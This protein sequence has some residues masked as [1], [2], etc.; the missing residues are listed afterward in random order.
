MSSRAPHTDPA[1]IEQAC[2]LA[3]K[4]LLATQAERTKKEI[5]EHQK[6]DQM[7]KDKEGKEFTFHLADE[8][9]R[10]PSAKKRAEIFRRLTRKYGVPGYLSDF[11]QVLLK[12][13]NLAS[14]FF[15]KIVMSAIT[16]QIR[17]DS[18]HVIL[19]RET[20][21][22][23]KSGVNI[24][25]L[26]EAILGEEEAEKRLQ[27]NLQLLQSDHC[28]YLSI[29]IS[30]IFSQINLLD[31]EG[32]I[33]KIQKRLRPLYRTGKFINLDMEEYRD[34]HL[35]EAVFCRTLEEPE[36]QSLEAGIVLQAYLPDSY[37]IL[38]RLT[39]W[40]KSR[41]K[42]IKIR[43][44]KGANLALEKVEASLHH[45]PQAPYLTKMEVDANYKR[46]LNY[47]LHPD[48]CTAVRIGVASHNLFD[49][50]YALLLRQRNGVEEFVELE[51]LEGMANDQ[52]RV[53]RETHSPVLFYAPMVRQEDFHSAIAYLIRRLDENTSPE[54]FLTHV[55]SMQPGDSA[56]TDQENR[57]RQS[58]ERIDTIESNPRRTQD[59]NHPA[60]TPSVPFT[61]AAD[62]DWVL[63]ANRQW[64]RKKLASFSLAPLP[65]PPSLMEVSK[66]LET[67]KE[68]T[69][70]ETS[71]SERV[72]I[73]YELARIIENYRGE[74]ITVMQ[75]ETE[76]RPYEAD[77]EVSE[78]V[79]F[80]NYYA[81]SLLDSSFYDGTESR[82][83]GPIVI[84]SPWNFPCAIPCGGIIAAL[85]MGNPVIFKP[86]PE[87]LHTAWE[88]VQFFWKAGIPRE[89]LQ[90]FGGPD[91]DISKAL[92]CSPDV[93]AVILTGGS[94]TAT[95]FKQWRPDLLLF[96]ETSGKNAMI[97]TATA[98]PDLAIK[99]LVSSAF[100]H[101]GQ[102]CSAASI[103]FIEAELYNSPSFLAQLR[104]AAASLSVGEATHLSSYVT[105]L[106]RKPGPDLLRG[107]TELDPGESWLLKPEQLTPTLWSP[108]IKM[109]IKTGSWIHQ[110]ELFGPVLS[111][112]KIKNLDEAITLQNSSEFGLTGG[113]HSLDPQEIATWCERVEVGNAYINRPMTGA[114]VRRQPFGGWK[115]S[116]V[117]PGAKAGG[118]NYLSQFCSWQE[119]AL[120]EHAATPSA[121]V[122]NLLENHPPSERITKAAQSYAY[123]WQEEFSQEHD[124]SQLHGESN[125]FRYR[126]A[127]EIV[128]NDLEGEDLALV[129][130]AAMTVGSKI[131]S[132]SS[133]PLAK[134]L[135]HKPLANGRLEL[136]HYLHEQSVSRTTHR[137]G[138]VASQLQQ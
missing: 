83:L 133:H 8:V 130:I 17:H 56:W 37:H 48:H 90:F 112:I 53:I 74:L 84:A 78:A 106:I 134:Y 52:A 57:F 100:G 110:T 46:M 16:R 76:K 124:P 109:G 108:G 82:P 88:M 68:S 98:D 51:M 105:P 39:T 135:T 29:K 5:E 62:T 63:P 50:S 126:P 18:R 28:H 118:P 9:F 61:N 96:A 3:S 85:A 23:T 95:L 34:L 47:A 31:E 127:P 4:L 43:I 10:P 121:A 119:T 71:H 77:I 111:L 129:E 89:A 41:P 104:D 125:H 70:P 30:S 107:L 14:R 113:I 92:I 33:Q 114:I 128:V 116:S 26:G 117:G 27:E 67:A 2:Q 13:G 58:C 49:I 75:R 38:Q 54:N 69:W 25:L 120:P 73:F 11:E 35:T 6:T 123:W 45:W 101:A 55:F 131:V 99:D 60:L 72:E 81:S 94:E 21:L 64:L 42:P 32:T 20:F 19:A 40:A 102:K 65:S 15:P 7:L 86:A 36:F 24:N 103:A 12:L 136:R 44:V 66:M 80:A 59:R 79:D 91:S 122:I 93:A 132:K 115:K 97:I 87:A 1:F 137:H 22:G 138:R